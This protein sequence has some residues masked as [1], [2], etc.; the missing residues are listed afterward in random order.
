MKTI[1][2]SGKKEF[3]TTCPVCG[4]QFS[5]EITDISMT[6]QSV[7]CPECFAIISHKLK[8]NPIRLNESVRSSVNEL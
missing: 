3:T 5:Y 7:T 8:D 4:C 2:K 1:I 6:S